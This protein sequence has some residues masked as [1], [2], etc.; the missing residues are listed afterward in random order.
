MG[1]MNMNPMSQSFD[2]QSNGN[3]SHM[4]PQQ[5]AFASSQANIKLNEIDDESEDDNE[6]LF[7][8]ISPTLSGSALRGLVSSLRTKCK[9]FEFKSKQQSKFIIESQRKQSEL[10]GQMRTESVRIYDMAQLKLFEANTASLEYLRGAE[11]HQTRQ[12]C[13]YLMAQMNALQN[14]TDCVRQQ[15]KLRQLESESECK[16]MRGECERTQREMAQLKVM[17]DQRNRELDELRQNNNAHAGE[18]DE[19]TAAAKQYRKESEAKMETP[20][21][22]VGLRQKLEQMKAKCDELTAGKAELSEAVKSA[23][24]D[25]DERE[26]RIASL[27]RVRAN[28]EQ[29]IEALSRSNRNCREIRNKSTSQILEA[30]ANEIEA[31]KE[32]M[33]EKYNAF[34]EEERIKN[35]KLCQLIDEKN[36]Q[37]QNQNVDPYM[38]MATESMDEFGSMMLKAAKDEIESLRQTNEKLM[39][40]HTKNHFKKPRV[41]EACTHL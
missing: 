41:Q 35:E 38:H 20:G 21:Q 15:C 9:H 6:H 36:A 28:L 29:E 12:E 19:A 33:A 7:M 2:H 32:Q 25:L 23:Q 11:L 37:I 8:P 39:Q 1:N 34:L 18:Y 5:L 3:L 40:L 14:E 30:Q 27:K 4:R 31:V 10:M 22:M 13:A 16:S 26:Q 17:F 24:L